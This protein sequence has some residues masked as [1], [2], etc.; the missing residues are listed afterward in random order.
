[1]GAVTFGGGFVMIPLIE[2]EVVKNAHWL[3]HQ[4]FVDG[5]ART[6]DP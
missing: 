5:M 2:Q 6:N 1:M 4:Q 3:T